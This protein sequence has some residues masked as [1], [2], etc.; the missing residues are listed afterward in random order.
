ML[1]GGRLRALRQGGI[2]HRIVGE[3]AER[4]LRV[5][6]VYCGGGGLVGGSDGNVA[7]RN[8]VLVY[9]RAV[10]VPAGEARALRHGRFG[11][12]SHRRAG[13]D[14]QQG[15]SFTGSFKA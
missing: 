1:Y 13:R 11:Q 15:D 10:C 12:L 14:A 2:A 7:F 5:K 6:H 8:E 9:Q 4:G 3:R